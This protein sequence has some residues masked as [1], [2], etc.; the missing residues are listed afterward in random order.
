MSF[1]AYLDNI[2]KKT[3]KGPDEFRK[4]AQEK[5]LLREE[6]KAGE[7]L[8]WLKKEFDLG[9]G[10]AMAIFSVLKK[11]RA[12]KTSPEVEIAKHFERNKAKWKKLFDLVISELR[13]CGED[14]ALAPT[15]AYISI[16]RGRRKIAI[17][18]VKVGHM[19]LGI[20]LKGVA[21]NKRFQAAGSWNAMMTHRV[22]ITGPNDLDKELF[23]WLRSA[24]EQNA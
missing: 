24:Y 12:E 23:N 14:I 3:G 16:L 11:D 22:R 18:Q 1:Q 19:D 8:A 6:L 9:H 2:K 20:K 21:P 15:N 10:H 5:G 17:V 4:L 13:A 7:I